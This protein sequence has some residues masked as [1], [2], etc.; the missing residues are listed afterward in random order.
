MTF[1]PGD[2]KRGVPQFVYVEWTVT[3]PELAA[4]WK[5]NIT[6]RTDKY[7][8]GWK[9]D[10]QMA[11][12]RVPRYSRSID[13]TTIITPELIAAVRADHQN[14]QLKLTVTFNNADVSVKA[15]AYRW[16]NR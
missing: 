4:W 8:P 12:S 11:I 3:N 14:T 1:M 13:L 16:R 15:E 7:S 10:Y 5:E 6:D 9:V 2:G